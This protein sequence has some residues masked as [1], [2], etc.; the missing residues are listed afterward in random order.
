MKYSGVEWIGNIPDDWNIVRLKDICVS[1]KEVAGTKSSEYERLALTLNGVVKRSKD[2]QDGLQPKEFDTYQILEK[3]D[4]VFKMIDLNN[5]STS[6]VGLSPYTGLVSPA[7]LRFSPRKADQFNEY[8]YY[9]LL[10]LWHNCIYNNIAGNGVRSA[11]NA[12]DMGNIKCPFPN[13]DLQK[14]IAELINKKTSEIDSLIEMENKQIEKLKEYKKS[15]ITDA[16]TKGLDKN[17][18]MKDSGVDWISNIPEGWTIQKILNQLAMP[19]TDGPHTTPELLPEGIA[20]VSAEA[21]SC[22]NGKIDFSHIRGYISEDF[23]N[24]CCL[25]Y[26]PKID[27]VY[28]IK[29]GATTGRVS[30][31]DTLEPKFTIWSPIAVMRCDKEKMIPKFLYYAVQ[32]EH[33]QRQIELGWSFGTQQNLG[34]RTLEQLKLIV[35]N[36]E[37]QRQIVYYLDDKVEKINQVV[38]LKQQ[39]IDKLNEYKKSLIYEYV[40]GKKEVC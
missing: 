37:R 27:D 23:Y 10:S 21:V 16:V 4:F 9:Y 26:I 12:I 24:E 33:F 15:M 6:R 13:V 11:L 25:K 18:P 36:L 39:K 20:F 8:L 5:I 29:S 30:I 38:E 1:K 35:P 3:N 28:M 34:M 22:G 31:V 32:S 19:V 2:A 40:T 17:A 7:Y 14:D